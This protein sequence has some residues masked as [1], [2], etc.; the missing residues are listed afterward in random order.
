MW[1]YF[2]RARLHVN[3]YTPRRF[4]AALHIV[5]AIKEDDCSHND[6]MISAIYKFSRSLGVPSK[7]VFMYQRDCLLKRMD[8]RAAIAL[9]TVEQV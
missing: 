3:E 4:A 2:Q 6:P 8:F 7:A 5:N 9:K 1:I